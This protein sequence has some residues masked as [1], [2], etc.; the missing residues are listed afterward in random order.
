[1][2]KKRENATK[3]REN[4]TKKLRMKTYRPFWTRL[5][6]LW[7]FLRSSSLSTLRSSSDPPLLC[8]VRRFLGGSLGSDSPLFRVV[9]GR[10]LGR[11]PRGGIGRDERVVGQRVEG[12]VGK[13]HVDVWQRVS[14]PR[15]YL[16]RSS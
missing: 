4:A 16:E 7:A 13:G 5:A 11:L 12:V 9:F 8:R 1:M 10:L 3:K 6:G 15:P 2:T 14:Q